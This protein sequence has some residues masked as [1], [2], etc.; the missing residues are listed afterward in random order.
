MEAIA[1][2]VQ[3]LGLKS[4]TMTSGAGHDAAHM[5]AV[6]PMGMIFIPSREGRSHVPEEFTELS[7]VGLG[8]R[9][10]AQ[11]LLELDRRAGD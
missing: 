4:Q 8:V 6:A 9:V 1:E 3:G 7:Q 10:L 11:T 2:A 5:A